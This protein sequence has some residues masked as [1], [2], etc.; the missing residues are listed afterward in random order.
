MTNTANE[1]T[2]NERVQLH[3]A[4]DLWMRGARW[5]TVKKIGRTLV[6]VHVDALDRAIKILPNNLLHEND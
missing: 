1:F 5:G 4:T 2:A 3:P 6:H